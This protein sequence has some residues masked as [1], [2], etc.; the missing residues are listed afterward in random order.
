VVVKIDRNYFVFLFK[1][2][3]VTVLVVYGCIFALK[4]HPEEH[5]GDRCAQLLVAILIVITQFQADLGLGTLTELI[6][7]DFFNLI[8]IAILILGLLETMYIHALIQAGRQQ[9][10]M[11]ANRVCANVLLIGIYPA[12]ILGLVIIWNQLNGGWVLLVLGVIASIAYGLGWILFNI[13]ARINRQK[14]ALRALK[15][16][17]PGDEEAYNSLLEAV[18]NAYDTDH[19]GRIDQLELRGVLHAIFPALSRRD[20]SDAAIKMRHV[21]GDRDLT[22]EDF[23]DG[24]CLSMI[25]LPR[26][27]RDVIAPM[28]TSHIP[29]TA[30]G[31]HSPRPCQGECV[32]G[33]AEGWRRRTQ[34]N[35][36][37]KPDQGKPDV[38]TTR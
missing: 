18:F 30:H 7:I 35:C 37:P 26:R 34:Y 15:R 12:V 27:S 29:S 5:T 38:A 17:D 31:V 24:E 3:F 19:S 13:R 33:E 23:L 9:L 32:R 6:W 4:L 20:L 14:T 28:L 1:S 21:V 22:F 16:G 36:Q 8:Q 11:N 25:E 2:I 10:A